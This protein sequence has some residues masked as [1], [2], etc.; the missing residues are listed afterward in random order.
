MKCAVIILC[1]LT[2]TQTCWAQ[3]NCKDRQIGLNIENDSALT[4]GGGTD[5]FY[6]NGLEL[7]YRCNQTIDEQTIASNLALRTINRFYPGSSLSKSS[8]GFRFGQKIFT[9]SD[10]S[11]DPNEIDIQ[12]D[13]PYAGLAL[14]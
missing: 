1:L 3:T 7:L 14:P 4:L 8:K 13:R 9:S 12:R 2:L 5:R 6:S 11:L 10:L